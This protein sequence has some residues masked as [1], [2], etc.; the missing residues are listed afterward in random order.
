MKIKNVGN[1]NL[2]GVVLVL[3]VVL[4]AIVGYILNIVALANAGTIGG[5]E[6]FR[7][8]GLFIPFVGSV[9]GFV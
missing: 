4:A 3:I 2:V 8:L 6:I 9:L 5:M 7:I 1:S